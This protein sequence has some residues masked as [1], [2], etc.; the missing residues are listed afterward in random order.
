MFAPSY[1]V[2]QTLKKYYNN[3][4]CNIVWGSQYSLISPVITSKAIFFKIFPVYI[5]S[6]FIKLGILKSF[7]ENLS[8]KVIRSHMLS[9]KIMHKESRTAF[10]K[11]YKSSFRNIE[12]FDQI[13]NLF[14]STDYNHLKH[15]WM[16]GEIKCV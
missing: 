10:V 8:I 5:F 3:K 12:N 2:I 1:D 6:F 4:N 7:F 11:L 14:M 16:V 13:I 15:W 9:D